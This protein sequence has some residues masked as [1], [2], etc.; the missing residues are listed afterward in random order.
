MKGYTAAKYGD[1]EGELEDF[2]FS[3]TPLAEIWGQLI[4]M[5]Y[6]KLDYEP[7]PLIACAEIALFNEWEAALGNKNPFSWKLKNISFWEDKIEKF[8]ML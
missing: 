4:L 2:N 3:W 5:W 8:A 7:H 1:F 6:L